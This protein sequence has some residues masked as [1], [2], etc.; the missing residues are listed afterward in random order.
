M[1]KVVS[2][3]LVFFLSACSSLDPVAT[4]SNDLNLK[5]SLIFSAS[6]ADLIAATKESFSENNWKILYEG[7]TLP[8]KNYST[9]SNMSHNPFNTADNKNYDQI[10]I[11]KAL[12]SNKA[13][14]YY[15]QVKTPTSAFSFGAEI[16]VVIYKGKPDGSA[17][18]ISASSGQAFEKEKLGGY[19]KQLSDQ[20]NK[21]ID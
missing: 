6:E 15:L 8:K 12:S 9:F 4:S 21:K 16:F 17:V 18:S 14:S 7:E 19:I 13:P 3:A 10:A 5:E 2:I 1:K 20:I 11:D